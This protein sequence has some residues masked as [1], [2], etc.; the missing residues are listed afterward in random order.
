MYGN[1]YSGLQSS[2]EFR[3]LSRAHRVTQWTRGPKSHGTEV[4]DGDVD[5]EA[6]GYS[7]DFAVVD[8]VS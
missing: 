5:L 3:T 6:F 1:R 8:R 2:E 4:E 7:L